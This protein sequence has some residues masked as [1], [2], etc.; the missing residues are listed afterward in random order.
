MLK[1]CLALALLALSAPA[2]VQPALAQPSQK[3]MSIIVPFAPGASAD[4]IARIMAAEL[5]TA[6]GRQ[7]IAENKAGAGGSLGL[8]LLSKAAPDG[9]TLAVGATGALVINPHLAESGGFD[10]LR[11]LTPIAKLIEIPLVVVANKEKGPKTIRELIERSKATPGGISYGSTGVNSGQHLIMELLKKETGAN[12]VHV[13]YRGSAP[14]VTDV[15]GGQIPVASLDLT[16]AYPHIKAGNLTV[17]GITSL[18]R[19]KIAPELPTIAENGLPGFNGTPGY[20]GLFAPAGT[21]AALVKHLSQTV[22]AILAKPDVQAKIALLAVEPA[23]EDDAAFAKFLA[24][25]SARW[26]A[27][28]Q[29]LPKAN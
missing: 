22:A 15:L 17:L 6:L 11:E 28:I 2:L 4:G 8:T 27:L 1:R 25:E 19:T 21:P 26:G 20:I 13:P 7:V 29:S 5:G 23:Y 9:N 24:S 16:S 12:L 10:P 14:A 3:S 18:K